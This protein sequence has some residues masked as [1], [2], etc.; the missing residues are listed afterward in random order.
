MHWIFSWH[1]PRPHVGVVVSNGRRCRSAG[2]AVRGWNNRYERSSRIA[3][4]QLASYGDFSALAPPRRQ[5]RHH[6]QKSLLGS[7][8]SRYNGAH[9]ERPI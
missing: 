5:N 7:E 1:P 8:A 9:Q 6:S 3:L 4:P 2:E